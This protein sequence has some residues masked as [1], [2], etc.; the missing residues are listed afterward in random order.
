V[1]P[2]THGARV[3]LLEADVHQGSLFTDDEAEDGQAS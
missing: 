3:R 1:H 2:I